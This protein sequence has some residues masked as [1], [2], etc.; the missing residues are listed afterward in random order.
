MKWSQKIWRVGHVLALVSMIAL[1]A[2]AQQV[3]IALGS[4]PTTLDPQLRE[5]GGE[6]AVNDNIYETL[7]A[8]DPAGHLVPG[9]AA[10]TPRLVDPQTWEVK[11]RPGI[12]F[13]NGEALNAEAVVFSVNRIIDPKF[14]SE[15]ISFFETIKAAKKIDDLTLQIVT[16]GPDPILLSR[17]YWMKIVPPGHTQDARFAERP[18]GTGPYQF[19]RWNRGQDILLTANENYWGDK[20]QIKEVKYRFV[21]E[22]GTRL[23]G[24]M[25]G[26]FDVIT[27]LL[28]EFTSQVPQAIHILGLEHPIIILNADSGPTKDVRVRQALNYAVDKAALAEGLFEGFAQVAQGQLLSPSFFGF[29]KNVQAYAYNPEKAKALLKEAGATGITVELIGTS[30]RWLKDRELVEAVA[31]YWQAVGIKAKVRIFEFNEYLNRLFDRKTRADAI[32][33]VSSN[34][35][36]DADKSFSAYYRS[37]GI[38]SSNSDKDLASLIDRARSETD[39]AERAAL[40]HQAVKRAHDQ[41]YFV[42]LLNIE[43]IYGVSARVSWPARVDAKILVKEMKI[44][45]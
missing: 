14:N 24:I 45:K 20:P 44:T 25:A 9:L 2:A 36:L 16:K 38:G 33:V 8:R 12:K 28:P 21:E 26:E 32:F 6:R 13:H 1:P 39:V 42:W 34:E 35:L 41:A 22:P 3:T 5:D 23:A 10:E 43:D 17:L 15:Q 27:N 30:G 37:G 29:N 7:M 11:L 31:A 40:Y 4:E 18:V 19:V